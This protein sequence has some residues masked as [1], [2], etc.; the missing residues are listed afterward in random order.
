MATR[1]ITVDL[2]TTQ[3]VGKVRTTNLLL[4]GKSSYKVINSPLNLRFLI[5]WVNQT[6]VM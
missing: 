6:W 3:G 4:S 1:Q 2:Q 5:F